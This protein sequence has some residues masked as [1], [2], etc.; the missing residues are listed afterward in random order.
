MGSVAQADNSMVSES[1]EIF[2]GVMSVFIC[3]LYN[4]ILKTT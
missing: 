4:L 3:K 1:S 2:M